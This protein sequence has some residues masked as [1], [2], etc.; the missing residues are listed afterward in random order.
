MWPGGIFYWIPR[1]RIVLL[2][3]PLIRQ[4]PSWIES[5]RVCMGYVEVLPIVWYNV[6]RHVMLWRCMPLYGNGTSRQ[7]PSWLVP[8][9]CILTS[10]LANILYFTFLPTNSVCQYPQLPMCPYM[11]F[12]VDFLALSEHHQHIEETCA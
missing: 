5:S 4:K 2:R 3:K 11:V 1:R 7:K 10:S 8:I 6:A 9:S 12:L